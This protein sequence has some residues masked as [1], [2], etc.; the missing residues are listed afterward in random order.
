MI[1]TTPET[2]TFDPKRDAWK[3]FRSDFLAL[4]ALIMLS[5]LVLTALFAPLIANPR[6]LLE[7]TPQTGLQIPFWRSFFAP[8]STE[9]F[10]EKFFN[11]S[12]LLLPLLL[13]IRLLCAKKF[14]RRI[15]Y[16]VTA[17]LL[18]LPFALGLYVA[19]SG[20]TYKE[21]DGVAGLTSADQQ[22]ADNASFFNMYNKPHSIQ[23]F[24]TLD[25]IKL[26]VSGV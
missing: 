3:R 15:L 2:E 17:L 20:D 12:M 8:E 6:P 23:V 5:I 19:L 1:R 25:Q 13:L 21:A 4:F 7:Y 10:I 26:I 18:L 22:H 16:A 24:K 9:F 11:Y 14:W